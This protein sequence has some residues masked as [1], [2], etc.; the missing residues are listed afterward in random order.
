MRVISV[1]W[2]SPI[3]RL[4]D[5]LSLKSSSAHVPDVLLFYSLVDPPRVPQTSSALQ[6]RGV[7]HPALTDPARWSGGVVLRTRAPTHGT[8]G[9]RRGSFGES[10]GL[11]LLLAGKKSPPPETPSP[12]SSLY[13][14]IPGQ[15][16]YVHVEATSNNRN[17]TVIKY[18]YTITM[19]C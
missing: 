11:Y 16:K 13:R 18:M 5:G 17:N 2:K 4:V 10:K 3:F 1:K 6:P 15:W 9:V 8:G 14:Y 12:L 7:L 19:F